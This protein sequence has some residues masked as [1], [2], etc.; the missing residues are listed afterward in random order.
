MSKPTVSVFS[1]INTIKQHNVVQ[2]R[3]Y[4]SSISP[5]LDRRPN[6][7]CETYYAACTARQNVNNVIYVT[8]QSNRHIV[9]F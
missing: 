6:G 8:T 4:F 9:I 2:Y 3:T 7:A 5:T 1:E